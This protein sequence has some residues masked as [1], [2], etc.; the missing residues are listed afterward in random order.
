M[1]IDGIEGV[2]S[3]GDFVSAGA[4]LDLANHKPSSDVAA[5][6]AA[7]AATA[8]IENGESSSKRRKQLAAEE[9]RQHEE[10]LA[11][12]AAAAEASSTPMV[13]GL[14]LSGHALVTQS[15][16]QRLKF[17]AP[18]QLAPL[19]RRKVRSQ[20]KLVPLIEPDICNFV[21]VEFLART[22]LRL[23]SDKLDA[24]LLEVQQ[25]LA[26]ESAYANAANAS[27]AAMEMMNAGAMSAAS[28]I[29]VDAM[30]RPTVGMMQQSA[31]PSGVVM[32]VGGGAVGDGGNNNN[33]NNGGG[34]GS[35][36]AY[37][38]GGPFMP[39]PLAGGSALHE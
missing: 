2:A 16:R 34:G 39:N 22:M 15:G 7:A 3:L 28:G 19:E 31:A 26:A 35:L 38:T 25:Q 6:L 9:Q 11:A 21:H 1:N 30:G 23:K 20:K 37:A 10:E 18:V 29:P 4:H 8:S 24:S 17:T 36:G 5:M 32:S 12:V 14:T 33:S 13:I 27:S